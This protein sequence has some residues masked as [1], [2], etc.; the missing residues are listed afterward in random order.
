MDTKAAG[1]RLLGFVFLNLAM[2]AGLAQDRPKIHTE[3][4]KQIN[5]ARLIEEVRH[6]LVLLPWYGVFDNLEYSVR[7]DTVILSG[8]V[9]RP[10][11]KSDAEARVKKLEEVGKVINNI[12]V[13]PLSPN[14]DRIRN[15]VYRAIF[16]S[17][18]L[19]M[20]S[21]RAVPPIHIIVKNG[22][23]TL[24]G[25]VGRMADKNEAGIRAKGVS[26]VFNV[27]NDLKV[28]DD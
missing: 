25:V 1:F 28:E 27:A 19:E 15:A 20:Y 4:N 7:G 14:D 9:T 24:T 13:L 8:Q 17:S 12:E 6:Q 11:L 26:G 5:E 22:N 21:M 16:S 18:G 23:V 10:V 2:L 3:R